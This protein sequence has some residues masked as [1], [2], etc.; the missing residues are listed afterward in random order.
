MAFYERITELPLIYDAAR[1][2][3]VL[4][5]LAKAEVPDLAVLMAAPKVRALLEAA[6]SCSPYL[7]S[8]ALRD[9]Q[10]LA[11]CLR[12][13]PDTHLTEA[14]AALAEAI[15][16]A[17]SAKEAMVLLRR[18]KQRIALLAGLADLGGVWPTEA[19]LRAMSDAGDAVL[20]VSYTHLTLPTT[21]YV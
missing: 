19:V 13:D 11:E 12:R 4:D 16:E 5:T 8:L 18:F 17:P 7:S 1:G 9:P 2:A 10:M 3:D 21:P 14:R 6:F 15:A 20:P